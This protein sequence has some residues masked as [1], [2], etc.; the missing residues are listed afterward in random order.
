MGGIARGLHHD[1]RQQLGIE[2]GVVGTQGLDDPGGERKS[3]RA[4]NR[5][6]YSSS[7]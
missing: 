2:L 6:W 5:R 3:G 7:A 4:S 1:A